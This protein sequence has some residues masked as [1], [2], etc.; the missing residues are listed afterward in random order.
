MIDLHMHSTFSDGS[1]TPEALVDEAQAAGLSAI[2][3]T[4]HDSTSGVERFVAACARKGLRGIGGVEMSVDVKKGTLHMLGYFVDP[5]EERL[6]AVLARIREGRD[7]RNHEILEKLCSLG[8]KLAW[9][10]VAA[11]A[12]E[13]VVSRPHFARAM[14]EKKYVSS[15]E[16]AFDRFL[17]KGK[18]A[19]VDRMRLSPVDSVA[20]IRGAGGVAVLAHP[21]TLELKDKALETYV[22][23][24]KVAGLAGI[25]VYYSE[26]T[27]AQ[28]RAYLDLC[29][30]MG[31]APAGGSDFHGLI[32][33]AIR[34]GRGFGNLSVPDEI[35]GDLEARCPGRA[36][37]T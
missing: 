15:T 20:A 26:H 1:L 4:D 17:G 7:D 29:R 2:A 14:V 31:L 24:L 12:G 9:D 28:Q 13:D 34:I 16:E 32:N 11:Y 22:G 21:F 33:P 36:Q 5:S 6:Q 35:L 27:P 25:E 10:E 19:Y 37:A 8:M 23:E 18:P 30:R 3:L